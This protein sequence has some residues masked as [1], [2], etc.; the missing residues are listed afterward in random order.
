[1]SKSE[2]CSWLSDSME[3]EGQLALSLF[4]QLRAAALPR[5]KGN[6]IMDAI[7]NML[8]RRSVRVYTDEQISDEALHTILECGL[9]APNGGNLQMPRFLVVQDSARMER[10]NAVIQRELASRELVDGQMMN[11][12]ILRARK[13]GYHFIHHAPT[14]ISAVAPRTY[15]NAMADCTCALE[16]MQLAAAALGLG[17]CWSNQP[18]WLTD[19][20]ALRGGALKSLACASTRISSAVYPSVTSAMRLRRLRRASRTVCSSI[21]RE[22]WKSKQRQEKKR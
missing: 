8:S 14:L 13:E 19:V 18:H 7:K 21:S 12:G 17:A 15:G 16:N 5:G 10:L 4:L 1:M 3:K 2:F 6:D 20:P 9:Y 11:R 22:I